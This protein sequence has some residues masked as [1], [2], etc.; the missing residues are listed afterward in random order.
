LLFIYL[1]LRKIKPYAKD[2]N[3]IH[4]NDNLSDA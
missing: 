2:R 4:I 3:T 1:H